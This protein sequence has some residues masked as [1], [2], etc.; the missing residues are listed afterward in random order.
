MINVLADR[1]LHNIKTYLSDDIHL[2]LYDPEQGLPSDLNS[3][4]GL[5]VRTVNPINKKTLGNIAKHLSFVGTASAGTD[6]VDTNFL[7]E[8]GITFAYAAGCNARSVAEYVATSLLIWAENRNKDLNGSTLGIVG[9]GHVGTEVI[10]LMDKLKIS[11][12]AYDPPRE[13]RESGF[14]S[15][16]VDQ[17]LACDML[18]FHTPLT[19]KGDYPTFHWLDDE[20]L[21][22][23]K[24]ELIINTA[25]GGVVDETALLKAKV[26]GFVDDI[27][28]DV[29][30]NE[31]DFDLKTAGQSFIKTPHIAGYSVQSKE[32]ASK[33][34]ADA[35]L[36]HS[37][38]PHPKNK[39]QLKPRILEKDINTFDSLSS[40]LLELHPIK[41][42]ESKLNKIIRDHPNQRGMYFNKLRVEFPLRQDFEHTCLPDSYFERFP[43]LK[44]LG[45]S[46]G[47]H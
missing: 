43:V 40:L 41:E 3:V 45:F 38:I 6:H 24:Y 26:N 19:T 8:N 36:N 1:Y 46:S 18:S 47:N 11:T 22:N 44:T 15:A 4:H 7:T 35:L 30:E 34:V 2:T 42:Y 14:I 33:T 39:N 13:E 28:I 9:A 20:K 16:S 25:R 21:S 23:R 5:L 17:L 27:I 37:D 10:K 29:W 12:V 32:N 31:P